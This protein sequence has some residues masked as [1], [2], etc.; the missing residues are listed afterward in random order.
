M[1]FPLLLHV[2]ELLICLHV[3]FSSQLCYSSNPVERYTLEQVFTE[4]RNASNSQGNVS[5][6]AQPNV[7]F[8]DDRIVNNNFRS[9]LVV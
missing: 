3:R 5:Y 8:F 6:L 1:F 9:M 4:C 7:S 2:C